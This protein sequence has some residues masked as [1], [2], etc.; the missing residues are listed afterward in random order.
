VL[1]QPVSTIKSRLGRAV[2][3]LRGLLNDQDG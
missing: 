2:T 1:G 3:R